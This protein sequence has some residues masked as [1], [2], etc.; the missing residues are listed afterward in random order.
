MEKNFSGV[1][2]VANTYSFIVHFDGLGFYARQQP[3]YGWSFTPDWKDA[4][5]YTSAKTATDLITRASEVRAY[6]T[7]KGVIRRIALT[8]VLVDGE[9]EQVKPKFQYFQG[10]KVSD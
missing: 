7:H 2:L 8:R 6:K 5:E 9:V 3:N 10:R 4:R 1:N